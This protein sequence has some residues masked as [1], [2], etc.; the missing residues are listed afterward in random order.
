MHQ[1]YA[2]EKQ[3]KH[4]ITI[5]L[6]KLLAHPPILPSWQT[7]VASQ[8]NACTPSTCSNQI[9]KT[10]LFPPLRH[11]GEAIISHSPQWQPPAQ[12]ALPMSNQPGM[13]HGDSMPLAPKLHHYQCYEVVVKETHALCTSDTVQF[14]HHMVHLPFSTPTDHIIAT[15]TAWTKPHFSPPMMNLQP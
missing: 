1:Q 14:N 10:R 8:N 3:F 11:Y 12:N 2:A 6:L 4:E 15:K 9:D 7:F 5:C 13:L